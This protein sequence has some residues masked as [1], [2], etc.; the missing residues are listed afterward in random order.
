MRS[1]LISVMAVTLTSCGAEWFPEDNPTI[2]QNPPLPF[3]NTTTAVIGF[4]DPSGT[5][6]ATNLSV[7][8]VSLDTTTNIVSARALVEIMNNGTGTATVQVNFAG[9]DSNGVIVYANNI[10]AIVAPATAV[11]AGLNFTITLA[12][13]TNVAKWSI[14][15]VARL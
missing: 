2:P 7:T 12:D 14:I 9:T 1:L 8:Q 11:Q 15:Q 10:T 13:F 4:K 5:I 6:I 3:T